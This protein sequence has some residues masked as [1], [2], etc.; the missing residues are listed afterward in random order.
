MISATT[1]V[2]RSDRENDCLFKLQFDPAQI[3]ELAARYPSKEDDQALAADRRDPLEIM[4]K[5]TSM[6]V[7]Y[8]DGPWLRHTV[9]RRA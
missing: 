2:V 4:R 3:P 6:V 1:K 9:E 7:S 8:D 5:K